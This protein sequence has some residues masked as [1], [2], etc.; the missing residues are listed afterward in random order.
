MGIKMKKYRK[1]QYKINCNYCNKEL[2]MTKYKLNSL[3]THHCNRECYL[4]AKRTNQI[5]HYMKLK[6]TIKP[7]KEFLVWF[8]GFVD[9]EGTFATKLNNKN[10][11]LGF[12]SFSVSQKDKRIIGFIHKKLPFGTVHKTT[13]KLVCFS[14]T[15][16]A[17][18][19]LI[20][21]LIG[22]KVKTQNKKNQLKLWG[23]YFRKIDLGGNK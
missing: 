5:E 7:N 21:D 17:K 19:K 15:G 9:G 16:Y 3:K 8:A 10:Y 22:K 11:P 20:Y 4:K 14:C 13:K 1:K 2:L 6:R 23:R 12:L 18:S